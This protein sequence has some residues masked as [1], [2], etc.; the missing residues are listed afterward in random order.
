MHAVIIEKF[1][2]D[3]FEVFDPQTGAHSKIKRSYLE[4]DGALAVAIF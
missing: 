2:L 3:Y 4:G 1:T